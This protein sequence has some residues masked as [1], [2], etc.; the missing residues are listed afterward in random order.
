MFEYDIPD[1]VVKYCIGRKTEVIEYLTD[2]QYARLSVKAGVSVHIF[3]NQEKDSNYIRCLVT[4]RVLPLTVMKSDLL[5]RAAELEYQTYNGKFPISL[6]EA[7]WILVDEFVKKYP[8]VNT[9]DQPISC[10]KLIRRRNKQFKLPLVVALRI[11]DE[12]KERK[13][14]VSFA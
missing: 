8:D 5:L 4:R 6:Q 11:A 1:F 2:M 3:N 7:R 12:R 9:I 13:C 10:L 14:T